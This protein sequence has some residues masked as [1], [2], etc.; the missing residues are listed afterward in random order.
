MCWF[1]SRFEVYIG[2]ISRLRCVCWFYINVEVRTG[3]VLSLRDVLNEVPWSVLQRTVH[4]MPLSVCIRLHMCTQ[5]PL[6]R[7][8]THTCVAK[9]VPMGTCFQIASALDK[10]CSPAH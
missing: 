8:H 3:P 7:T 5:Q 10:R 2:I 4:F 1:R 6:M 9:H